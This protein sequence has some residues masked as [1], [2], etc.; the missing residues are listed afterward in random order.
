MPAD[1]A[2]WRQDRLPPLEE[3]TALILER[4]DQWSRALLDALLH[5]KRITL[6]AP[7]QFERPGQQRPAV[8]NIVTDPG[9]LRRWFARNT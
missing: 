2:T 3:Y 7:L 8:R 5:K 4:Q 1:A 9:E 6:P